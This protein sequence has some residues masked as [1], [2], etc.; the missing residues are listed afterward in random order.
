MLEKRWG[1]GDR[2]LA[3]GMDCPLPGHAEQA[4]LDGIMEDRIGTCQSISFDSS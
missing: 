1:E 4:E 2:V 3:A